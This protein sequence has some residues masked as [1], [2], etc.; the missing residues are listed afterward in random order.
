[1][2]LQSIFRAKSNPSTKYEAFQQGLQS[3]GGKVAELFLVLCFF[4]VAS[5]PRLLFL[6]THWSSDETRWLRRSTQFMSAVKQGEFSETLIAHHPGVTT[7]WLAGL[8]T[9]F[10]PPRV[11]VPNL[12]RARWFIGVGVWIGIGI[13]CFLIYRL[14]GRWVGFASFASLA[15]SPLFLAQTRRVHTDALATVFILLTVLFFL[16][17]CARGR[18]RR[19]LIA[20]GIAFGLAV[21]S[22]SYALI[23]VLWVP[24]CFCLFQGQREQLFLRTAAEMLC[25]LNCAALT[26]LSVWPVFWTLTF[27]M[28]TLCL[29]SITLLLVRGLKNKHLSLIPVVTA[30]AGLVLLGVRATQTIWIVLDKV[31]WAVTTPHEVEHFFL[32]QV[33]NDPGWFFYPF[34]LTIK[35]TPL[36][37][38]FA[39]L[40]C[41]WL[42]RQRHR[43][44]EAARHWR[45]ALAL[46]A[47]VLLFTVCLSAT[48]KKF[49]RYL[50][51][52]FP[53]LEI[54]SAIG[55]VELIRW[56]YA[57]FRE[58]TRAIK[59]T[60]AGLACVVF[61]LIQV[62]PVLLLHPY[63]GTY[64]N[65]CWKITDITNIITVGEAS[66]LDIAANYLNE[67]PNAQG[68]VVQVSPLAT[69][70]VR[71]YFQ[72]YAYRADRGTHRS[73]DY[74][75]VYIRDS[76]IGRV[77]QTG[78]LNGELEAVLTLNGI[79][80]VW[81][82][83]IRPKDRP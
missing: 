2:V 21:L 22:K 47:A 67:K 32:G 61:F 40:G 23:L 26:I 55:F 29:L 57:Y 14:F 74:E 82:Y 12:A 72:G 53:L 75:V 78:T 71:R 16:C 70:F 58:E 28:M 3:H 63:Y 56:G 48:S 37:L 19:Y 39:I 7:M 60:L 18:H 73:P 52:A 24:F 4:T 17:Y 44:E 76:Q 54:L 8:R 41:I 80:S 68:L 33:V 65:P 64:Y 50:L 69:E 66:G 81:I 38:P 59:H 13:A 10:I 83:R 5:V 77:P 6:D 43:S 25:F 30:L 36:M 49:S 11:D 9:F 20:A 1:M 34:V 46:G 45:F 62:L 79:E 15:A 42:W 31:G 35:S 27:G 51:P